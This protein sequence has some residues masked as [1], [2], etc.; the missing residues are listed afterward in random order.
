[1]RITDYDRISGNDHVGNIYIPIRL[2][3]GGVIQQDTYRGG[4]G[5]FELSIQLHCLPNYFDRNCSTFCDPVDIGGVGHFDCGPQGERICLNGW[6]DPGHDCLKRKQFH[7]AAHMHVKLLLSVY[8]A[9][10]EECNPTGGICT[11]PGNCT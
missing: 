5:R 6:G 10:C 2:N 7:T 8:A 3:P 1:M 11:A 9:I 4:Y